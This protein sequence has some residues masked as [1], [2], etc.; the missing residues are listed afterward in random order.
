MLGTGA[1]KLEYLKVQ[2]EVQR[3]KYLTLLLLHKLMLLT[4]E[5]YL[6]G[7]LNYASTITH[8]LCVWHLGVY[9]IIQCMV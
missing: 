3:E 6:H 1:H 2:R 4:S 7:I 8:A 5:C 9:G